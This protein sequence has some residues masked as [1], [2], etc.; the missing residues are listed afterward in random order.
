MK[1][2]RTARLMWCVPVVGFLFLLIAASPVQAQDDDFQDLLEQVGEEYARAYAS[3]FI[4]AFGPN[5]NS[6]MFQG[7]SIPWGQL[8]FGVGIKVMATHLNED[9]QT[10]QKTV[11]NV[12]LGSIDS[13]LSGT[14]TLILNGPTVFGDPDTRGTVTLLP[15]AGGPPI[16]LEGIPGLVDSRFVPLMA[17]EAS[18]GG[19][20]GLKATLRYFPELDLGDYGKT[21]YL[22]FG[23][24]W[25]PNGLLV[26][27]PVDMM[28]GFFD[29]E[30]NVGSLIEANAKTMFIAV[31]KDFNP[32]TVYGGF[33][34]E[35][36]D[37]TV[38]YTYETTGERISFTAES[39]QESR[40]TLGAKLKFLSAEM[41]VGKLTTY[42]AGAMFGF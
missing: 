32:L 2:L 8:T 7:A 42:S 40:L 14:G 27:F 10:F 11:R 24:Q 41:G 38:G 20:F 30:M 23:L 1:L 26:D 5:Q 31:S 36:A 33:A 19:V 9:D 17:P 21:K 15:D 4:E 12:D 16:A 18:V 37:M 35:S 39:Q 29:Q 25:S 6:A 28:V 3:P 34:K 13:S 22:G